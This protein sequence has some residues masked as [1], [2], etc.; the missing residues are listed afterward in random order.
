[1]AE[2]NNMNVGMQSDMSAKAFT[3]GCQNVSIVQMAAV[4]PKIALNNFL[5]K[6]QH[7]FISHTN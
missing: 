4:T 5:N 1:M 6:K 3:A 2:Y 7:N